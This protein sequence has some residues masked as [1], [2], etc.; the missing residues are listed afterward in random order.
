MTENAVILQY[1]ADQAA[2]SNDKLIAPMA[3]LQRYHQLELVNYIATELHKGFSPLFSPLRPDKYRKIVIKCL[4]TKFSYME[5]LLV[6]RKFISDEHFT[7]ADAYLFTIYHWATLVNIDLSQYQHL[8]Q[9][10]EE[11]ISQP[12]SVQEALTTEGLI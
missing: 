5:N 1:I 4:I 12:K 2:D 8:T 10:V 11:K 6:K 7:I 9:Y 3:S